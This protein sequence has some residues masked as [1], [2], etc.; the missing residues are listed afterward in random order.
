MFN[1]LISV[2]CGVAVFLIMVL[3]FNLVWWGALLTALA[4]VAVVMVVLVKLIINKI[5]AVNDAAAKDL[6]AQRIDKAIR[7]LKDAIKKYSRWQIYVEG[8]LN[9]QIGSIYYMRRDFSSAFPHLEKSFVRNWVSMAMLAICYMKRQKKGKM[10]ETFEKA[11]RWT[12]KEPLLWN[13]YAYC[14]NESGEPTKARE[15]LERGIRKLPSNAA[16]KENM[17]Q[18]KQGKKMKMR[19]YGDMWY[20]FHLESLGALQKHQM[21]GMGGRMQRRKVVRR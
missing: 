10:I 16:L 21:A 18:L 4:V 17:E 15:A 3:G 20:Q 13:V 1:I 14:L 7:D 9:A 19:D 12:T 5:M 2:G 6:Q 11:V 8:Q